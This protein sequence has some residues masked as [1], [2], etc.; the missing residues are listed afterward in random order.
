MSLKHLSLALAS[1]GDA[2]KTAFTKTEALHIKMCV[3]ASL[4]L[5]VEIT[6]EK[7]AEL[8][9]TISE[10]VKAAITEV[11]E[12]ATSV[13][14]VAFD[15]YRKLEAAN[16]IVTK[17]GEGVDEAIVET[18]L[19]VGNWPK[20]RQIAALNG[21]FRAAAEESKLLTPKELDNVFPSWAAKGGGKKVIRRTA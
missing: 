15:S 2:N 10:E 16:F 17:E 9:A 19:D 21:R 1:G 7:R 13:R 20:I 18:A 3:L 4:L 8:E 6:P 14:Q 11:A 5:A 12:E